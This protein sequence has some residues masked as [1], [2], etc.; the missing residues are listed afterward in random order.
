MADVSPDEVRTAVE[1]GSVIAGAAGGFFA[2]VLAVF[3]KVHGVIK[4]FEALE[5]ADKDRSKR[6]EKIDALLE[7]LSRSKVEAE[8]RLGLIERKLPPGE[9]MDAVG[10]WT[11]FG[12]QDERLKEVERSIRHDM[13]TQHTS[14]RNE[15]STRMDDIK[16]D[17]REVSRN[18]ISLVERD[19]R[20]RPGDR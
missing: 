13:A 2:A 9:M 4:R 18:V 8:T 3:W 10:V 16:E 6:D 14:L 17:V 7:M 5:K 19:K 15:L 1:T 20:S 11:V 12:K